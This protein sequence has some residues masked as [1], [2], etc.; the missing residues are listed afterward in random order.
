MQSIS[1]FF[2]HLLLRLLL[3]VQLVSFL[4]ELQEGKQYCLLV[5]H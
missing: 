4:K 5:L 2:K 1:Y 3:A